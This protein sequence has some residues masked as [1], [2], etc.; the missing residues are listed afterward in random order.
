MNVQAGVRFGPILCRVDNVEDCRAAARLV[1]ERL[2][3]I[4][5]VVFLDM[6]GNVHLA[7]GYTP[8]P[9]AAVCFLIG[10][11]NTDAAVE[12]IAA[13]LADELRERRGMSA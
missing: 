1:R 11:Y 12:N 4:P 2:R 7:P 10:S 9:P 6:V 5:Q 13:D 3:H 8:V